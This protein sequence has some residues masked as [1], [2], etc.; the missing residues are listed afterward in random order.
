MISC[1]PTVKLRKPPG[2]EALSYQL[3]TCAERRGL[4][5]FTVGKGFF[6]RPFPSHVVERMMVRLSF[7]GLKSG[8]KGS[9]SCHFEAEA[10]D[11]ERS[12]INGIIKI[13]ATRSEKRLPSARVGKCNRSRRWSGVPPET[14]K[15]QP[16]ILPLRCTQ[17]QDDKPLGLVKT[18]FTANPLLRAG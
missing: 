11:M 3:V 4:H 2:R 9:Q 6:W 13:R 16:R 12:S 10:L 17:R 7:E 15:M 18:V 14:M 5:C 1:L 8:Q